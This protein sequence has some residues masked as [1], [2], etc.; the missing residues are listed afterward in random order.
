MEPGCVQRL[1]TV[2]QQQWPAH[3]NT[4]HPPGTHTHL[5]QV[6]WVPCDRNTLYSSGMHGWFR[7]KARTLFTVCFGEAVVAFRVLNLWDSHRWYDAGAKT[8]GN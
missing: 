7:P 3:A 5:P 1:Q 6:A 4:L 8:R 2:V